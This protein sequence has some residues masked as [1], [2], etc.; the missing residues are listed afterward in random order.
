[1]RKSFNSF[2]SLLMFGAIFFVSCFGVKSKHKNEVPI[3][4]AAGSAGNGTAVLELF[5]SQ[6]C[7]SCPSA[8]KLL[9]SFSQMPH[10]IALAFHV[11]YW[12]RM[13]WTDPY[14]TASFTKRQLN[15]ASALHADVYTPQLIVNGGNEM[16]GSDSNKIIHAVQKAFSQ[17]NDADISIETIKNENGKA[18]IHYTVSG[19]INK[20]VANIAI[21][22]KQITTGVKAGENGGRTLTE[23]NVVRDFVTKNK[24]TAGDND[25]SLDIPTSANTANL[26][27]VVFLQQKDNKIIAAAQKSF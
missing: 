6:G 25:A 27:I 21:V 20:S 18:L 5:T 13:G 22:E 17:N 4:A 23:Y 14:S 1:M 9:G 24:I 3:S 12:N 26:S 10:I 19:N 2:Y 8:D 11:D 16:I 15:Y 7:S